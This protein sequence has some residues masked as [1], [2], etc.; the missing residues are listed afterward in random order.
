M[1]RNLITILV[2]VKVGGGGEAEEQQ[3]E[4]EDE[5]WRKKENKT[6]GCFV[7]W[8]WFHGGSLGCAGHDRRSPAVR[9]KRDDDDT[10]SWIH[11]RVTSLT[12][13]NEKI[14]P[15]RLG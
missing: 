8:D 11:Q 10:R 13:K 14:N 12:S 4:A 9:D 15:V 1:D 2:T 3:E 5:S 7:D 6:G